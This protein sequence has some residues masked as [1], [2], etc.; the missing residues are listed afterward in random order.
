M[1]FSGKQW[2]TSSLGRAPRRSVN[3]AQVGVD[4]HAADLTKRWHQ[5]RRGSQARETT[6]SAVN[7]QPARSGEIPDW[8][9]R[10]CF[11]RLGPFTETRAELRPKP[12]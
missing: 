5:R 12:F 9:R 8:Q 7:A 10:A 1:L 6:K 2:E 4:K 11:Q 3:L